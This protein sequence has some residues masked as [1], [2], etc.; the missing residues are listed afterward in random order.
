MLNSLKKVMKNLIMYS[1]LLSA[2]VSGRTVG[3]II[4][5]LY[6]KKRLYECPLEEVDT[7][8]SNII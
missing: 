2:H 7:L 6:L 1:K 5:S 3:I 8:T 4:S